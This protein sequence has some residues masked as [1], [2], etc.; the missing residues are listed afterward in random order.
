MSYQVQL[1]TF[2]G[3]LDL[4]LHLIRRHE[5]DI[6]HIPISLITDQYLAS[7]RQLE[8]LDLELAADFLLMAATLMQIKAR[9]LLPKPDP[10]PPE[11]ED[12]DPRAELARQ[13]AEYSQ[14][15][16]AADTLAQRELQWQQ[17][18]YRPLDA[19]MQDRSQL[20]QEPILPLQ[21]P[22]GMQIEPQELIRALERIL[23]RTEKKVP[24]HMA[25]EVVTMQ[26]QLKSLRTQLRRGRVSFQRIFGSNPQRV[27]IVVT[28]LALLELV[29]LG[30]VEIQQTES[31]GEILIEGCKDGTNNAGPT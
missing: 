1:P 5:I 13:L 16:T 17:V 6:Y 12:L 9:M 29:R 3:P 4:L 28:F 2:T 10:P 15:R 25:R 14:F 19:I 23:Q 22:S 8:E 27:V 30:E 21:L 7:L 24:Q 11:E 18:F 20:P 31:Y 26:G